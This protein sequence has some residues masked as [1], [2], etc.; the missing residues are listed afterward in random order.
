MDEHDSGFILF[1]IA[2]LLS[3]ID[4]FFFLDE[5]LFVASYK[6]FGKLDWTLF[7]EKIILRMEELFT[8]MMSI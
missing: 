6:F 5:I 2:F 8:F 7:W 4:I 3:L 1:Y